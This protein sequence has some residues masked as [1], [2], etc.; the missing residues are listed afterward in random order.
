MTI[1]RTNDD[2]QGPN[3][4]Y[5]NTI[6]LWLANQVCAQQIPTSVVVLR[7]SDGTT[8]PFTTST[9]GGPV[10]CVRGFA[11]DADRLETSGGLAWVDEQFRALTFSKPT[12]PISPDDKWVQVTVTELRC[13]LK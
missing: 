4:I 5:R 2:E 3:F 13:I 11:E 8:R 1:G 6:V 10:A 9:A 12:D 7:Y